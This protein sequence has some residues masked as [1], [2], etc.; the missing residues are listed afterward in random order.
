M[1]SANSSSGKIDEILTFWFRDLTPEQWWRSKELDDV[2]R[3]RFLDVYEELAQE[4]PTSWLDTPQGALAAI[5]VLDQFPR[6]IFR[7]TK[8]SFATDPIALDLSRKAIGKEFDKTLNTNEKTFL[9]MPFQHSENASD[10]EQSVLLF[11]SLGD[12][13]SYD[14]AMQHK[15]IIDRFGRFPHRNEALGRVSTEEEIAFL[16]EG[17]LFW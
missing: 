5:L 13:N 9:Y 8:M 10:Q 3:E 16:A 11:K 2:I 7:N 4:V 15:E 17:A 12:K 1:T 14:F 6:N